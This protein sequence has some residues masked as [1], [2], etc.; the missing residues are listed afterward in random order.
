MQEDGPDDFP[1]IQVLDAIW[2]QFLDDRLDPRGRHRLQPECDQAVEHINVLAV[3]FRF[4]LRSLGRSR[5]LSKRVLSACVEQNWFAIDATISTTNFQ[6]QLL[7]F[8]IVEWSIR[9]RVSQWLRERRSLQLVESLAA[10]ADHACHL[11]NADDGLRLFVHVSRLHGCLCSGWF[12]SG[13]YRM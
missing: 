9:S 3:R 8:L 6:T 12:T 1:R 11:R 2:E 10:E 4:G 13:C 7:K 5:L